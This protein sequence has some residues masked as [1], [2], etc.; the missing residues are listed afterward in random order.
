[1]APKTARVTSRVSTNPELIELRDPP[2]FAVRE[3]RVILRWLMMGKFYN[4]NHD[5]YVFAFCWKGVPLIEF[6]MERR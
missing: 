5:T 6:P 4:V 1:M 3:S 2:W